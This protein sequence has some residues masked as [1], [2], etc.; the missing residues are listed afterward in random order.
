MLFDPDQPIRQFPKTVRR[1]YAS[2]ADYLYDDLVEN[3]LEVILVP[4]PDLRFSGHMIRAVVNQ[5][6]AWYRHLYS[7]AAF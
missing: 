1:Y 5:N 6:P 3:R 4:P 2:Q 7:Y